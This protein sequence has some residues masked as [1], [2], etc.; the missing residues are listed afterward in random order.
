[1]YLFLE[2]PAAVLV[3]VGCIAGWVGVVVVVGEGVEELEGG[4]GRGGADSS[5]LLIIHKEK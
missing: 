2:E 3:G 1:V 5:I 4:E